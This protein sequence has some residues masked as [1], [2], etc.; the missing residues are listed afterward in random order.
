MTRQEALAYARECR[1]AK[2]N[3]EPKPE[4]PDNATTA[5]TLLD[6]HRALIVTQTTLNLLSGQMETVVDYLFELR[7]RSPQAE[8]YAQ[9]LDYIWGQIME[10]ETRLKKVR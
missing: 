8:P 7:E 3:G 1:Q 9:T 10:L 4:R 6:I 5:G 2:K